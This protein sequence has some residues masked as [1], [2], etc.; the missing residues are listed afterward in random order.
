MQNVPKPLIFS[1]FLRPE[2][3]LYSHE[4]EARIRR[5]ARR[6]K[7][8]RGDEKRREEMK[9]DTRRQ[10]KKTKLKKAWKKR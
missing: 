2:I 1:M 10:E 9:G 5:K 3:N 4:R 7:E 8:I 6:R